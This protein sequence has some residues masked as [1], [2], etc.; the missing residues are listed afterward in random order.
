MPLPFPHYIGEWRVELS[1]ARLAQWAGRRVP[2]A[3]EWAELQVSSNGNGKLTEIENVIF[4]VSYG[5]LTDERNFYV[6]LHFV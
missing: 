1:I 5:I 3:S 4:Y 2:R 6:S